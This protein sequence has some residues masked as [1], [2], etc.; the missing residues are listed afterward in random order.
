MGAVMPFLALVQSQLIRLDLPCLPR[1]M[2]LSVERE[3]E[4]RKGL[5]SFFFVENL[6][7]LLKTV[8]AVCVRILCGFCAL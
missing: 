7:D 4:I 3:Q 8:V 1:V 5:E 6:A 2:T